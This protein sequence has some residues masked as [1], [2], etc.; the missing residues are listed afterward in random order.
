MESMVR[1]KKSLRT[2]IRRLTSCVSGVK[3]RKLCAKRRNMTGRGGGGRGTCNRLG[4][5]PPLRT[6]HPKDPAVICSYQADLEKERQLREAMNAQKNAER[7]AMRAHF[8][9]K[10]QLSESSKDMN[11][12]R[13]VGGKVSLPR[14]LSK[15]IHP[16]TKTKD[17]GFNL[18]SAFQGLSFGTAALTGKRHSKTTTPTPARGDA[19]RVM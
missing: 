18:L 11:H 5:T 12:L 9:R 1:A 3:E 15:I 10:Y 13:S 16:E 14:E 4:R 19:C 17:N 6:A 7:A 2:P 8:R